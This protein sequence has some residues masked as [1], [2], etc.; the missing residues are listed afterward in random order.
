MSRLRARKKAEGPSKGG[1][2]RKVRGDWILSGNKIEI[3][4]E[5]TAF[6]CT[7]RLRQKLYVP[8]AK[9]M[10]NLPFTAFKVDVLLDDL[11]YNSLFLFRLGEKEIILSGAAALI[12]KSL[13]HEDIR[14]VIDQWVENLTY[15]SLV[16]P[17]LV[18]Y[19]QGELLS[20]VLK[21]EF[22]QH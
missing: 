10:G 9:A 21:G 20:R 3:P 15:E 18:E 16:F 11:G 7:E 13:P 4:A 14:Y 5:A 6:S 12:D 22:N 17:N 2:D 19:F 1:V 8:L